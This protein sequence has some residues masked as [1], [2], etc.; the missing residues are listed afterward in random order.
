LRHQI[1]RNA[2]PRLELCLESDEGEEADA[3]IEFNEQV[4]VAAVASLVA[5][6]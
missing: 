5:R 4:D 3:A 1:N 2:K 6:D